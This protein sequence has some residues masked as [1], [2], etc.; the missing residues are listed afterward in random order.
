M[1]HIAKLGHIWLYYSQIGLLGWKWPKLGII[2]YVKWSFLAIYMTWGHHDRIRERNLNM[3]ILW[4]GRNFWAR[5]F[6]ISIFPN[7]HTKFLISE[8]TQRGIIY[9]QNDLENHFLK[10]ESLFDHYLEPK[11]HFQNF[12]QFWL[13]FHRLRFS[14]PDG[15]RARQY[16]QNDRKEHLCRK[17]KK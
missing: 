12:G 6:E 10:S 13:N 17:I 3:T 8:S 1:G 11:R 2:S 16:T 15:V 9:D 14:L 5:N 7:Y 4:A